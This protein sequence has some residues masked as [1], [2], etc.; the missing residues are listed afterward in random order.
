MIFDRH[1]HDQN[2]RKRGEKNFPLLLSSFVRQGCN[3][4]LCGW[5]SVEVDSMVT[6]KNGI[7]RDELLE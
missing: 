3:M 1:L 7:N 6:F 2:M 4:L 5:Q